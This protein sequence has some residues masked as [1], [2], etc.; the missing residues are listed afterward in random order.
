[1]ILIVSWLHHWNA[2]NNLIYFCKVLLVINSYLL[3]SRWKAYCGYLF[4]KTNFTRIT[5]NRVCNLHILHLDFE[6]KKVLLP[7][8]LGNFADIS[9]LEENFKPFQAFPFQEMFALCAPG[10]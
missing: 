9:Y 7:P 8:P 6:L 2:V 1:M 4:I 10:R 3:F 5:N